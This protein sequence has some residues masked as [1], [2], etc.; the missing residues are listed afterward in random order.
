MKFDTSQDSYI[1]LRN[2]ISERTENIYMWIGSGVEEIK[3]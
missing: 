3:C 2:I 1:N